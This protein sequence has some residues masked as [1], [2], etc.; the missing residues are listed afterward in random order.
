MKMVSHQAIGMDLPLGFPTSF[1][2]GI[3]ELQPVLII[4]ENVFSPIPT[5]HHV[6]NRPLIF[7]SQLSRHWLRCSQISI[8]SILYSSLT[9]GG[10]HLRK[11]ERSD[12][13]G[14]GG[15]SGAGGAACRKPAPQAPASQAREDPGRRGGP[16]GSGHRRRRTVGPQVAWRSVVFIIDPAKPAPPRRSSAD[17]VTWRWARGF[18]HARAL[19][20]RRPAPDCAGTP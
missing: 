3:Q 2:Q 1:A 15:A 13:G 20:H 18:V 10:I 14:A 16:V 5:I 17:S 4:Q 7:Q 9:Q 6:V 19:V 11:V 12:A 8:M